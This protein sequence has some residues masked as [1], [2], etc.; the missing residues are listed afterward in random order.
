MKPVKLSLL[1]WTLLYLTSVAH[2]HSDHQNVYSPGRRENFGPELHHRHYESPSILQYGTFTA[3]S[4]I[5]PKKVAIN[6][7]KTKLH[8]ESD[9]T[10]KNSY[11]SEHNGVTHVY[12]KQVVN[13]IPVSN[14]DLNVNVDRFG[15]IISY[16]DSFANPKQTSFSKRP[17]PKPTKNHKHDDE[18]EVK[19]I[20]SIEE[21]KKE[22]GKEE[23]VVGSYHSQIRFGKRDEK[24]NKENRNKR[25][26]ES[27]GSDDLNYN[28]VN[29]A[30]DVIS[31][32]QALQSF[33]RYINREIPHPERITFA[34]SESFDDQEPQILISNVPFALSEV[35]MKQSYFQLEDQSLQLVWEIEVEM[36]DNWYNAHVNAHTGKVIGLMDWVFD[37]AYNVFPLGINDPSEGGRELIEDPHDII[38]SPYGWHSHGKVNFTKTISNNV[39]AHE[40][41]KG[42]YEWEN[43]YRPEG[44]ELLVFDFPLNLTQAPKDYIN[45]SI[46]NLFYWNNMVNYR[47]FIIII[48]ITIYECLLTFY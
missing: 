14:G 4:L 5:D 27:Y 15:R 29:D 8:P 32:E 44:G 34:E 43:N 1:G 46:T 24:N 23:F 3:P 45:A 9:F 33:S 16:G 25:R 11:N 10:I 26:H 19:D 39:Y 31:P 22:H 30:S 18:E 2:S 48:I 17:L 36:E 13:G 6:F 41:L 47:T 40:N 42:R 38:A 7:V 35:K 28:I 20:F 12:F 21:I 37:A